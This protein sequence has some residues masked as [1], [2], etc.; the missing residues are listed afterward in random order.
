MP[1]R[2][3]GTSAGALVGAVLAA[4]AQSGE[5]SSAQLEELAMGIDYRAFLDPGPIERLPVIGPAWGLLTGDGIYRGEAL[6]QWVADRLAEL[7]CDDVRRPRDQRPGS[8]PPEQRYR[9]VVTVA[10]VTWAS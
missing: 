2:I 3:S 8:L 4:A 1:Q 5:L 7:R 10:D 9:L 6:R